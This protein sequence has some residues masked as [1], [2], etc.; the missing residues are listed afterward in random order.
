MIPD[1]AIRRDDEAGARAQ[2]V[3]AIDLRPIQPLLARIVEKYHPDQVWLY[4]SRARGDARPDSDWDLFIVAPDAT[5][6]RDLSPVVAGELRR[7]L[8]VYA[9]LIP[10]RS[11]EFREDCTVVN[12]LCNEVVCDGV[13]IYER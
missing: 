3:R 13:V 5:D 1:A 11:S 7:G 2:E 8:G 6:E 12:T 10:C 4:G 9:D